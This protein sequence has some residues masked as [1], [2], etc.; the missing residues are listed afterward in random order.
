MDDQ[1]HPKISVRL[2]T[3][4]KCFGPGIAALLRRVKVYH[5]LRSAAASMGMAYS[6]AWTV[7]KSCEEHLGFK[8]VLSTVGGR[9]GGGAT[10][11]DNAERMLAAYDEY[12]AELN[13]YADTLLEEKFSF[14]QELTTDEGQQL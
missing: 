3:D 1:L 13:A 5:S 4:E 11:T 14:Y 10:L 9:N 7:L 2:F 8:L 6:K 12:C